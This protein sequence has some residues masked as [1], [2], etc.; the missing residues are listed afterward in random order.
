MCHKSLS[1]VS[2]WMCLTPAFCFWEVPAWNYGFSAPWHEIFTDTLFSKL[3]RNLNTF[4]KICFCVIEAQNMSWQDPQN[5]LYLP[6]DPNLKICSSRDPPEATRH[7]VVRY[8][9][10]GMILLVGP[11]KY[12]FFG[13]PLH[14][15]FWASMTQKHIFSDLLEQIFT[16]CFQFCWKNCL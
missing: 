13:G 12:I 11:W 5:H 3:S 4:I 7:R 6:T 10:V 14:D 16:K 2:Q 8:E 15:I 1:I 9:L